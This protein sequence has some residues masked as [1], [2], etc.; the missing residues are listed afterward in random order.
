VACAWPPI[1]GG[2]HDVGVGDVF[3]LARGGGESDCHRPVPVRA[4]R[5]RTLS[6]ATAIRTTMAPMKPRECDTAFPPRPAPRPAV[7]AL[8]RSGS[9]ISVV[10]EWHR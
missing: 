7:I 10:G 1:N 5:Y 4:G 9:P 8:Y 6:R 2:D 3:V